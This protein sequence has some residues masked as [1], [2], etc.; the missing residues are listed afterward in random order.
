MLTHHF[1]PYSIGGIGTFC[2]DLSEALAKN[3]I[4]VTVVAGT[5]AGAVRR[6]FRTAK[7]ETNPRIVRVGNMTFSPLHVWF[8]LMNSNTLLRLI[9]EADIVHGQDASSFPLVYF[10]H[11]RNQEQPWA[12]TVHSGPA[13]E[14]YYA[15]RSVG[16]HRS[17]PSFGDFIRSGVG[18]PSWDVALRGDAKY[19]DM[20]VPVSQTLSV[21]IERYLTINPKKLI[22]IPTGVNIE[23]LNTLAHLGYTQRKSNKVRLFWAGRFN[24]RKGIIHLVK[25]LFHLVHDVG[26]TNFEMQLFGQGPLEHRVEQLVS[27][28]NLNN[29]VKIRGFVTYEQLISAEST[30]DVVCFPSLYEASPVGMIEGMSLGKPIVAF[31]AAYAREILGEYPFPL[32]TTVQDYANSLHRMCISEDLRQKCGAYLQGRA[33]DLY[34]IRK[35]ADSYSRLFEKMLS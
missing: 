13:S 19:A 21:E 11:R 28:M 1:P 12:V 30:S 4:S 22:T 5:P 17:G 16:P 8:Q 26:F 32:A 20:L 7:D 34:D 6:S 25:S 27:R 2:H 15:L 18:F 23:L 9:S 3:G 14:L 35:V 10:S 29:Y 31:N 33:R 24:W